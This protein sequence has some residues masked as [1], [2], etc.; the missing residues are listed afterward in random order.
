MGGARLI[1]RVKVLQHDRPS[2]VIAE[3]RTSASSSTSV[4]C[5]VENDDEG[6]SQN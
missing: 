6:R 3:L 1:A 2:D 5:A 4:S